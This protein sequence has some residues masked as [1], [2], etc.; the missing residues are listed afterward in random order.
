MKGFI[1]TVY[2]PVLQDDIIETVSQ[3]SPYI[4][5]YSGAGPV[6]KERPKY[7]DEK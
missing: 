1:M 3:I 5:G 4:S 6:S 2:Q 7:S